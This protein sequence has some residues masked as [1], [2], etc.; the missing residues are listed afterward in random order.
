MEDCPSVAPAEGSVALGTSE[1]E[2]EHM[3]VHKPSQ[4]QTGSVLSAPEN[5]NIPEPQT[6]DRTTE[7]ASAS[8]PIDTSHPIVKGPPPTDL[9]NE[10]DEGR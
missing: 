1:L 3:E 9:G 2:Y 8:G 6:T 7:P 10:Q 5:S 4:L